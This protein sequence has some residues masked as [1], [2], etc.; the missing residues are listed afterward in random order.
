MN[1][2]KLTLFILISGFFLFVIY[3]YIQEKD[4]PTG[5]IGGIVMLVLWGLII[6]S[7]LITLISLIYAPRLYLHVFLGMLCLGLLGLG[8]Q[9]LLKQ[10]TENKARSEDLLSELG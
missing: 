3:L 4:V 6:V 1:I 9:S 10:Q 5:H 7:G 2:F 8:I